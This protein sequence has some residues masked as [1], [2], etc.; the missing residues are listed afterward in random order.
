MAR[1]RVEMAP[2]VE[3]W[4]ASETVDEVST[5]LGIKTTSVMA[6]ASKYRGSPYNIPLKR[7]KKAG[8]NK[9]DVDAAKEL[10]AKLRGTTVETIATESTKLAEKHQAR[11]DKKA[12]KEE[13]VTA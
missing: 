1:I 5:K 3:A 11:A 7:M 13:T 8:A 4:E 2:F 6:R 12:A 9:L 10:L